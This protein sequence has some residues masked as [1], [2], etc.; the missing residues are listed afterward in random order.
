M[1]SDSSSKK[2]GSVQYHYTVP[3]DIDKIND[4]ITYLYKNEISNRID[5]AVKNIKSDFDQSM[6]SEGQTIK[7]ELQEEITK[8]REE[9]N[10]ILYAQQKKS[11]ELIGL[12]SAVIALVIADISIVSRAE[13]FF[14]AII[15][16]SGTT[17]AMCIFAAII[18][19]FF[20][21]TSAIKLGRKF[22]VPILCLCFMLV[23]GG[24]L[25]V[26]KFDLYRFVSEKQSVITV[27]QGVKLEKTNTPTSG[28][29]E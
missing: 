22:W 17:C 27:Q 28:A 2:V 7:K 26:L 16:I 25:Y 1:T 15:L 24:V 10:N 9:Y 11:V 5:D 12:F 6:K 23:G 21:E 20:S 13:T 8:L 18:H 29:S 19:A 4:S 14:G 3:A